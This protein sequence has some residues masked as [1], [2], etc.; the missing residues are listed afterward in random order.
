MKK[1]F[2]DLWEEI[3]FGYYQARDY[4]V[5]YLKKFHEAMSNL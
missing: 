3:V 2:I 1:F 5:A 4:L